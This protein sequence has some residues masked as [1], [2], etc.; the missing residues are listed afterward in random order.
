MLSNPLQLTYTFYRSICFLDYR[1]KVLKNIKILIFT[2]KTMFNLTRKG[3]EQG[4]MLTKSVPHKQFHA[5]SV[6]IIHVYT[7]FT[8]VVPVFFLIVL[9]DKAYD[10]HS[11]V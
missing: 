5:C 3:K 10:L 6:Y 4:V 2:C 7:L 1:S 8:A 11:L 9:N